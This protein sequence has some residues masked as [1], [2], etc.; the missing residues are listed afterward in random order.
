[1]ADK[2]ILLKDGNVGT[3]PSLIGA[4]YDTSYGTIRV[5]PFKK[6]TI[7]IEL[8]KALYAHGI[9]GRRR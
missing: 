8:Q 2:L 4:D 9:V 6:R 1:M 3:D 5:I 7:P